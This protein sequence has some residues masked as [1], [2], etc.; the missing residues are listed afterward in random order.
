M[1]STYV[2]DPFELAMKTELIKRGITQTELFDKIHENTGLYCDHGYMH[3]IFRNPKLAPKIRAA[4][5]E[6]LDIN[7]E[8]FKEQE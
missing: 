4:V 1:E 2:A 7:L 8:D 6:I 3:K 5:A